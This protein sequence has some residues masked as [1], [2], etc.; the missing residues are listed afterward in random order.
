VVS[1]HHRFLELWYQLQDA[2]GTSTAT[3]WSSYDSG[4]H[5]E[6]RRRARGSSCRRWLVLEPTKP[7]PAGVRG[8]AVSVLNQHTKARGRA[9]S[10]W[11]A[12]QP[13]RR[14]ALPATPH[15]P[16][17]CPAASSCRALGGSEGYGM[18]CAG[19]LGRVLVL[20]ALGAT[21]THAART[22]PSSATTTSPAH[23]AP[24]TEDEG[25]AAAKAAWTPGAQHAAHLKHVAVM[26]KIHAEE[27]EK[28]AKVEAKEAHWAARAQ[29]H[30]DAAEE[31]EAAKL[32]P[33]PMD[34]T[35]LLA[36]QQQ[37]LLLARA[38]KPPQL[39]AVLVCGSR[40]WDN[41]RHQASLYRMYQTLRRGISEQR[42]VTMFYDDIATHA[43]NP[44]PGK[45]RATRVCKAK[46]TPR[47]R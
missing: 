5:L 6:P 24:T 44:F 43:D 28:E 25:K 39:W 19:W 30:R 10:T 32:F 2:L 13:R 45:V 27:E 41:Y 20:L 40:G 37:E 29:A 9:H 38:E 23:N 12:M 4:A 3:C 26:A 17:T 8:F 18:G 16:R 34:S 21:T 15:C 11:T 36:M 14:G 35:M 33:P 42:I 22:A 47:C 7:R 1:Q 46:P 31:A